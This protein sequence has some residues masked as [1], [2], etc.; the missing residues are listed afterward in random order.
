EAGQ[1]R[2]APGGAAR[3]GQG[4]TPEPGPNPPHPAPRPPAPPPPI[5]ARPIPKR[6]L[7]R[8]RPRNNERSPLPAAPLPV[9]ESPGPMSKRVSRPAESVPRVPCIVLECH[10]AERL[11]HALPTPPCSVADVRVSRCVSH[12]SER[13][14]S[15]GGDRERIPHM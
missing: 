12:R 11:G 9:Q 13:R 15:V 8:I 7:L 4:Q 5:K 14:R 1:G 10:T 6:S 3:R 2:A